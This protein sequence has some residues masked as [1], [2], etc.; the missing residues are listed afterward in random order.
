MINL[1][2]RWSRVSSTR[3]R[4]EILSL[5]EFVRARSSSAN[6]YVEVS[7]LPSIS[8]SGSQP[9]TSFDHT[10]LLPSISQLF[11]Y[12]P[13]SERRSLHDDLLSDPASDLVAAAIEQ[14]QQIYD[15]SAPAHL[16]Y[17]TDMPSS[18]SQSTSRTAPSA[19]S[20]LIPSVD[21]DSVAD[22]HWY[23]RPLA[24]THAPATIG[25]GGEQQNVSMNTDVGVVGVGVEDVSSG[26]M[27]RRTMTVTPTTVG[28]RRPETDIEEIVTFLQ[29]FEQQTSYL[30][31]T[32]N[33]SHADQPQQQ[34]YRPIISSN[35]HNTSIVPGA[36]GAPSM[37]GVRPISSFFRQNSLPTYL[38][39]GSSFL[40][41]QQQQ[42]Q[43]L[44]HTHSNLMPNDSGDYQYTDMGSGPGPTAGKDDGG[45]GNGNVVAPRDDVGRPAL[46]PPRISPG[47]EVSSPPQASGIL[48]KWARKHPRNQALASATC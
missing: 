36:E 22:N 48:G 7:P 19:L 6:A 42:R 27:F 29:A 38:P 1:L 4:S 46:I 44:N 28:L 37:A 24:T 40:S 21:G 5:T 9:P 16:A 8:A 12:L 15:P 47:M 32:L 43:P 39:P 23:V 25:I 35:Y 13:S 33:S 41:Y 30:S 20:E 18:S 26:E 14:P 10:P 45:N 17:F 34:Q 3:R 11:D 31:P 2:K